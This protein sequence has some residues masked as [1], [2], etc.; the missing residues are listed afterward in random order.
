M[1]WKAER[2]LKE[3]IKEGVSA[4]WSFLKKIIGFMME[5]WRYS[6]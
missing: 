5:G 2:D 3:G 1:D 6:R 4:I